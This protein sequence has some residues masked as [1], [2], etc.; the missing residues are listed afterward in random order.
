MVTIRGR[1]KINLTLDVLGLRDDGYHEIATVMQSLALAD[2][3]T[4]TREESGIALTVDMPGLETD[5]RNLAWR[6]AAL[7]IEHC[8][9]RGGVRIDIVKR[10]P[11][12][13]GLAG[14]SA[15]A[16]A[17]LRGMNELYALGLSNTELCALGA[18]IGSD[19]PFS[20][21]GGTVFATGRGENMK[22]LADFPKIHVVLAKPPVD[23]STP[24]AYRAYDAHPPE[25]RPDNTAFLEALAAGDMTACMRLVGNVLEPVTERA[26][27]IVGDYRSRMYAH[28]AA[29][30]M[31][32]GSGPTVF[33]LFTEQETAAHTA[34]EFRRETGAA[35]YLT[36]T[37]GRYG[38]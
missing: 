21:M 33:G 28:G 9:I 26:H 10:I 4:L 16:A 13:A 38:V 7:V 24:W 12:A 15:D 23:V 3:L 8:G 27:P 18:K 22:P 32:S 14:G 17:V 34:E 5:E 11:V 25:Q 2:T 1:A 30:A 6:A 20:L 37:A 29:C 35:V 19:I 36:Q 31:M